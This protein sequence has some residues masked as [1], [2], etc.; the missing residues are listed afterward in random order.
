MVE[1][2]QAPIYARSHT[3]NRRNIPADVVI[4]IEVL[5]FK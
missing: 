5:I 4:D 1:Q 2:S 3:V